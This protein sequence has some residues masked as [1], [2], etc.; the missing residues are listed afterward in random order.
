MFSL[1]RCNMRNL[2]IIKMFKNLWL[3]RR[4]MEM[5]FMDMMVAC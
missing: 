3:S 2:M 1:F 5:A 4:V